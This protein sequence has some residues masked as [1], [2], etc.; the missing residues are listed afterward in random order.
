MPDAALAR[1]AGCAYGVPGSSASGARARLPLYFPVIL[2]DFFDDAERG[3]LPAY[4]F[5][6][7]C[8]AHAHNDYHPAVDAV[9]AGVEVDPPSSILGGEELLA[10]LYTAVRTSST[11]SGSNFADTLFLV[12]FD[13]HGG[14]Y[15]APPRVDPSDP[16]A[17]PDVSRAAGKFC[18]VLSG[19]A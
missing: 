15:V 13:E 17:R 3:T 10:R 14:T 6:E 9:F 7:P 18:S 12:A 19:V 16:A 11:A 4:S 2:G 5:I 8:L 1:G